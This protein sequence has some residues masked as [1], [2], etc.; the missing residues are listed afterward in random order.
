M[1][2]GRPFADVAS[3]TPRYFRGSM[4]IFASLASSSRITAHQHDVLKADATEPAWNG[5]LLAV[6]RS[7]QTRLPPALPRACCLTHSPHSLCGR[8]SANRNDRP[9][10]KG[11]S[12]R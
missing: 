3:V 7:S 11:D 1:P 12:R 9:A 8:G 5:Y 6:A 4:S 10:L 2:K